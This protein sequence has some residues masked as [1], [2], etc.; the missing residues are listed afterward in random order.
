MIKHE[1]IAKRFLRASGISP[2]NASFQISWKGALVR[3]DWDGAGRINGKVILVEVEPPDPDEYHIRL[4]VTN[5]AIQAHQ[6]DID[7]LIWVIY[8]DIPNC[9][10]VLQSY[11][12]CWMEL[13]STI[14][15]K[16]IAR[17]EYFNRKGEK[18]ATSGI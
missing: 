10:K 9:H 2:I 11:A 17:M 8:S 5:L 14:S 6:M 13:L 7:R 4:H 16:D 3:I 18:L 15:K 12:D 1:T